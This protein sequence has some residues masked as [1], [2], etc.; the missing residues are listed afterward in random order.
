MASRVSTQPIL[1]AAGRPQALRR[2]PR[3]ARRRA[4][5]LRGRGAL[6]RRRERLRQVDDAQDPLGPGAAGRRHD[7]RSAAGPTSF[8]N[9]TEAL[10]Q[11]IATVT[12]ETTLAQDLTIAENIFLGHRMV[13]RGRFIDWS[14]TR[15]RAEGALARLEL[16]LDPRTP[17]ASAPTRPA[18]D[19]RDRPRALDR[20]AR[21]SSSTSRRA[22]SPTTR[23]RR[24]SRSCGACATR[25]S[26]RSS[27]PTGSARSS[28]SADRVTVLRDGHTV[29][30][31]LTAGVRPR[32]A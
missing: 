11:G 7:R 8:R 16:D 19:G 6:A 25:A 24:S 2:R 22:R 17:G 18:A 21:R 4:R 27:S 12:Q 23:S 15:R 31:G 5:R 3:P 29:G 1:H 30:G 9:P 20:R 32:D 28:R 14:A 26:R 10:R 13:R